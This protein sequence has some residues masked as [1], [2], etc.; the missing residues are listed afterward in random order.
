ML[1]WRSKLKHCRQC[2][3][4]TVKI[5]RDICKHCG[6]TDFDIVEGNRALSSVNTA[7][8]KAG[9]EQDLE[10]IADEKAKEAFIRA[11]SLAA[12]R[13]SM[14]S[15]P[16]TKDTQE[17][18]E[19]FNTAGIL[20]RSSG[21]HERAGFAFKRSGEMYHRLEKWREKGVAYKSAAQC[22]KAAD[23]YEDEIASLDAAAQVH[24]SMNMHSTAGKTYKQI[25]ETHEMHSNYDKAV[26]ACTR[27][28]D[29]YEQTKLP[30]DAAEL[31]LK[32]A[33]IAAR[34]TSQ[35]Q[36]AIDIFENAAKL[37]AEDSKSFVRRS[38]IKRFFEAGLCWLALVSAQGAGA[39][40]AKTAILFYIALH[41]PFEG[42]PF[43][44]RLEGTCD[45]LD[46]ALSTGDPDAL[47]DQLATYRNLTGADQWMMA[48][49][50][51]I[52]GGAKTAC[53]E[54]LCG[55]PVQPEDDEF[56]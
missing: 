9:L 25:A 50:D 4:G 35:Y 13:P 21:D 51:K 37:A 22:Y 18:A 36:I 33:A 16:R 38:A 47:E 32:A 6:C 24:L 5:E 55:S 44:E 29:L 26:S 12:K 34:Y 30:T 15:G 46:E 31:N 11:E 43:F 54:D 23:C 39:T 41:P 2:G 7:A 1:S 27:A 56:C 10:N 17:A 20:L 42:T 45:L 19:H 52:L 48:M 28:A 8:V 14:F 3:E 49:C 40:D 53:E